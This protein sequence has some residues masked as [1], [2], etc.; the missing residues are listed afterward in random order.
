L[1]CI[2]KDEKDQ[3]AV[4]R[5]KEWEKLDKK[6]ILDYLLRNLWGRTRT[7]TRKEAKA[8]NI[9]KEFK[10]VA[11]GTTGR[12]PLNNYLQPPIFSFWKIDSSVSEV[13][14]ELGTNIQVKK[15]GDISISSNDFE[16]MPF[17]ITKTIESGEPFFLFTQKYYKLYNALFE[18]NNTRPFKQLYDLLTEFDNT[19]IGF[20][21][22]AFVAILIFYY[23]KFGDKNLDEFSLW[24][25]HVLFY[26]RLEMYSLHYS[27]VNNHL[28]NTNPFEII[29]QSSIS[30]HAV[31]KLKSISEGLYTKDNVLQFSVEKGVR[32]EYYRRLYCENGFYRSGE[33]TKYSDLIN[34]KKMLVKL[35]QSNA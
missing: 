17:Q 6:R 35:K 18:I 13:S 26:K 3:A 5:S 19:G 7:L 9:K 22:E 33:L 25:E 2:P 29:E 20:L 8:V 23:D 4:R 12:F 24:V 34:A 15:N 31:E 32:K 14:Y 16:F 27:T 10:A 28:L 21:V 30:T 1:R 11:G